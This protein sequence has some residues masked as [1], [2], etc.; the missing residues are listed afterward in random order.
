MKK[1]KDNKVPLSKRI[2]AYVL[3]WY[4]S[5]V[6]VL[7]PVAYI[8]SVIT[9]EKKINME[10]ELLKSPYCYL[11]GALSVLFGILYYF[12]FPLMNDGQTLGK[13]FTGIQIVNE[14]NEKLDAL[15]LFKRQVLGVM[16]IESP[17]ILAGS[18]LFKMI[19]MLTLNEV[20]VVLTYISVVM[21]LI[22]CFLLFKKG[23]SLHDM[24]A[25]STVIVKSKE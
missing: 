14:N 12:V 20:S 10:L 1:V 17:F 9:G 24:M 18:Y 4:F 22:S 13:K 2:F 5:W 3:D 11:A 7:I 21:F 15:N 16:V 8:S 23:R 19:G 6:F 25:H